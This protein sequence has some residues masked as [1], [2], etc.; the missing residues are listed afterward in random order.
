MSFNIRFGTANDGPNRWQ[1]RRD[2]V[3]DVI[4]KYHPDIIGL[5]EALQFQIDELGKALPRYDV[6]G[7][8]RDDGKQKGEFAAILYDRDRFERQ[9]GGTFWF[10]DTP[11]IV[12]STSWGNQLCRICTWARF[13]DRVTGETL[14]HYNVHLDH[15]S[16]ESRLR[17]ARLVIDRINDRSPA[18]NVILTGDFNAGET[19]PP[20][21]A[22]GEAKI[23]LANDSTTKHRVRLLDSYRIAHPDEKEVGTFDSFVGDRTGDKIDYIFVPQDAFDVIDADIARDNFDGAYPSDHFPVWATLRIK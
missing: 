8:G 14:F 23:T 4:R 18:S 19:S 22:I 16:A 6:F 20:I 1:M 3:F 7:V 10:S 13:R 5:Q 15:A 21:K 17:S 2:H 12:C 9:D 11:E